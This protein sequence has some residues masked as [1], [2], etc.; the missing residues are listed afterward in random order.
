MP[1]LLKWDFTQSIGKQQK[2]GIYFVQLCVLE[3]KISLLVIDSYSVV[4]LKE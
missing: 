1:V 2:A 3:K 4:I